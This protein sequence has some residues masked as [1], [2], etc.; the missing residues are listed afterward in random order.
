VRNAQ[1]A[2]PQQ[3]WIS[4]ST[5]G[6]LVFVTSTA[7]CDGEIEPD[8][9]DAMECDSSVAEDIVGFNG[10]HGPVCKKSCG[11]AMAAKEERS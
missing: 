9:S 6:M 7:D 8:C 5:C 2:R 10:T 1:F 3:Q 11:H 4:P